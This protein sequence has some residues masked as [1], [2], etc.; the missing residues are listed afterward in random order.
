VSVLRVE[1]A[2]VM[3]TDHIPGRGGYALV[4]ASPGVTQGERRLLAD[5]LGIS[6]YLHAR[7]NARMYFS[8]FR[9][10]GERYAFVRRFANGTRRNGVQ[11]RL[12]VHTLFLD[13]DAFDALHALPWLLADIPIRPAGTGDGGWTSLAKLVDPQQH[14]PI[15]PALE[16]RRPAADEAFAWLQRRVK[17]LAEFTAT[18]AALS[19]FVP[20]ESIARAAAAWAETPRLS[21]PQRPAYELLTLLT[22]SML[23]VPDRMTT[24]WTQHAEPTAPAVDFRLLNADDAGADAALGTEVT[25]V[26]RRVVAINTA[27]AASWVEYGDETRRYGMRLKGSDLGRWLRYRESMQ[28]LVADPLAPDEVILPPLRTL[29]ASVDAERRDPWV[30]ER[31]LLRIIWSGITGAVGRGMASGAAIER[32]SRL[33]AESGIDAV[34]FRESPSAEWLDASEAGVGADL[35]IHF[36]LRDNGR[37]GAATTRQVVAEW[38]LQRLRRGG[39]ISADP[40]ARLAVALALDRS[41]LL[42][43]MLTA[44]L[45]RADGFRAL[46]SAIRIGDES[47]SDGVL[48]A[49]LT[50]LRLEHRDAPFFAKEVLLPHMTRNAAMGAA[51]PEST[52]MAIAEV[53]RDDAAAFARFAFLLSD[54]A[55]GQIVLAVDR[56]MNEEPRRTLPLGRALLEGGLQAGYSGPAFSRLAFTA[57]AR[58]ERSTTWLPMILA[59]ARANDAAAQPAT[60]AAFAR[61]ATELGPLFA[62]DAGAAG[63]ILTEVRTQAATRIGTCMRAL[64]DATRGAWPRLP[65]QAAETIETIVNSPQQRA[66]EW[67]SSVLAAAEENNAPLLA[68]W[69][70]ISAS[71]VDRLSRAS[72]VAVARLR[73][74]VRGEIV[75][76]WMPRVRG[77]R[78]GAN[79]DALIDALRSLV[80]P[81]LSARLEGEIARREIAT[82]VDTPRTY[83][84]LDLALQA[85]PR[86]RLQNL[87]DAVE[88]R[89]SGLSG[90]ARAQWLIDLFAAPATL[91]ITAQVIED[92]LLPPA[93]R[94][95]SGAEWLAVIKGAEESLFAYDYFLIEIARRVAAGKAYEAAR[96]LMSQCVARE[97]EA[98]IEALVVGSKGALLPAA[99]AARAF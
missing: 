14:D 53:M 19:S 35:V 61:K 52:A 5:H 66:V 67:E 33:A 82:G 37:R 92:H 68:F 63:R 60:D 38:A 21:L 71:D 64:L 7:A 42:G 51:L 2:L 95:L 29:A 27:D 56:W 76:T 88:E 85:D 45:G 94:A 11:N 30:N 57:A 13:D 96:H 23:P 90:A 36:F 84:R 54:A 16:A 99:A 46:S 72:I 89:L 10:P 75:E 4:S 70:R 20:G 58:R 40:L 1:Q 9:I 49:M 80:P 78:L 59:A 25:A 28:A 26:A 69:R 22:W 79:A 77:L 47:F 65:A 32:W 8:F 6:D 31:A 3:D 93:L 15:V 50:G 98:G 55:L 86:K 97:R 34:I 43:E 91:L 83:A 87:A 73:G 17:A 81:A 18:D 62:A 48:L 74:A 41:K 12:F 44:L 39:R 24:A